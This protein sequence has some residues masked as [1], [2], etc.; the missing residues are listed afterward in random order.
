MVNELF[1]NKKIDAYMFLSEDNRF[2]FTHFDTSFGCILVNEKEKYFL[3]DFRYENAARQM[4]PDF[5]I[6]VVGYSD[7]YSKVCE[8][9]KRMNAKYVGYEDDYITVAEF[10]NIK[11]ALSDFTLKPASETIARMRA[12]KTEEELELIAA[13]E[14]ITQKALSKVIPL[15]KVGITEKEVSAEILFEM[16]RCGAQSLAFDNIVAFGENSA[17]PHHKSGNKKLEKNDLILIDIG[18]KANGYCS[19]MTRTFTLGEPNSQLISL[20][21][22]VAEAQSYALKN[23]RAGMTCHEAD[24]LAREYLAANGYTKEFGHSLGHGVGINVHEMPRVAKGNSQVLEENMVISVEPGVYIDG[25]G[26]VRIEDLV[27]VKKDGVVNL[28]PFNKNLNF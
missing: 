23:I 27:I 12:V 28:T 2:Y 9:L 16:I 10:K 21:S 5:N 22:I 1:D 25:L 20:H 14:N 24:S 11:S 15:I 3:T 4:C 17:Q 7:L 19:D 18:C 13:A 26:G 8:I 6:V